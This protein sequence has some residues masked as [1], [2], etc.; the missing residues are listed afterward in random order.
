M[1]NA[2]TTFVKSSRL[3]SKV[4]KRHNANLLDQL[5]KRQAKYMINSLTELSE[6]PLNESEA[7]EYLQCSHAFLWG[8][9]KTGQINAIKMGKKTLYLKSDLVEFLKSK[10][11]AR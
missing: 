1:Q 6:R 7:R 4:K 3:D 2:V 9:R 10:R 5:C 11:E 8:L